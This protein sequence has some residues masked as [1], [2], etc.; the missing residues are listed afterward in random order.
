M[1]K[2]KLSAIMEEEAKGVQ[3]FENAEA[4]NTI[5][6]SPGR[7]QIREEDI[8]KKRVI[9]FSDTEF[10][11]IEQMAKKYGFKRAMEFVKFCVTKE[12]NKEIGI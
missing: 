7:P 2:L 4:F 5:P 6:K 8:K 1:S 9:Y 10:L 12:I 11:K 3:S